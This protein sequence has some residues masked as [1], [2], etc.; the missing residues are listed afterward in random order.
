MIFYFNFV[1]NYNRH[2]LIYWCI[3]KY[4]WGRL[5]LRPIYI[6]IF[7]SLSTP[8]K[9]TLCCGNRTPNY[10]GCPKY[11]SILK[12]WKINFPIHHIPNKKRT[13]VASLFNSTPHNGETAVQTILCFHWFRV[14]DYNSF[15]TF[16]NN[17]KFYK[18]CF[19]VCIFFWT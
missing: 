18:W 11:K 2:L 9:C 7:Q 19:V 8:A 5:H 1:T 17:N 16:N 6:T 3:Y 12:R 14:P 15:K 13:A 4:T 10:K